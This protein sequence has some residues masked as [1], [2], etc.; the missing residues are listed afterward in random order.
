MNYIT[1]IRTNTGSFGVDSYGWHRFLSE[2]FPGPQEPKRN[3]LYRVN[4]GPMGSLEV[5]VFSIKQPNVLGWETKP[6]GPSYLAYSKYY[7]KLRA[8]P[9]SMRSSGGRRALNDDEFY[10][11]IDRKSTEGG[12]QLENVNI[13]KL[14]HQGFIN[15]KGVPGSHL[16]VEFSGV[17]VV[18]DKNKFSETFNSGIGSAKGY[19]F[20]MLLLKP[21]Q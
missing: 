2:A 14:G 8:N 12:F 15:K 19:G 11:W 21:I 20:G 9:T 1:K 17:L 10:D 18:V 5:L 7:F 6:I 3:F 16:A 13:N 4:F